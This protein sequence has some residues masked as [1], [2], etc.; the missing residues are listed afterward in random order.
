MPLTGD[1]AGLRKLQRSFGQMATQ[2]SAPRVSMLE[3]VKRQG[4]LLLKQEFTD[5][6]SATGAP[7]AKTVRGKPALLSR[8]LPYAFDGRI[9][10]DSLRFIGRVERE[11]LVTMQEGRT[12]KARKVAANQ[13]FLSFSRAGKLVKE[14]R[15]FNKKGEVRRGA[16]QV[17]AGEH[18][19]GQRVL[20]PR[21]MVP[22]NASGDLP[23]PW[24]AA[25]KAG[26]AVGFGRWS[27]KVF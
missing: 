26:L 25:V 21:P 9:D 4:L 15:I 27:S 22:P 8:K 16:R 11:W 10:R 1:T 23:P 6:T 12:F 14:S 17:F 20:P 7:F 3:D 24:D 5:S 2:G 18:T 19:V 13:Q